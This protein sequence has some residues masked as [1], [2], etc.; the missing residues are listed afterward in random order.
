MCT[1]HAFRTAL[2]RIQLAC[3]MRWTPLQDSVLEANAC[4]HGAGTSGSC[5]LWQRINVM[6]VM[7]SLSFE[8]YLVHYL[9]CCFDLVQDAKLKVVQEM[10]N[11]FAAIVDSAARL[12]S[13]PGDDDPL[14]SIA[15]LY[16]TRANSTSSYLPQSL[17]Q[18]LVVHLAEAEPLFAPFFM[19][20]ASAQA[21]VYCKGSA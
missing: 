11:K 8:A 18:S 2:R 5:T 6:Q 1:P 17:S 20:F 9:F 19:A 4:W 14:H 12:A 7:R 3:V 15:S 21:I 10:S 13:D 16:Q